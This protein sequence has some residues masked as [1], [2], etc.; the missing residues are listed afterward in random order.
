MRRSVVSDARRRSAHAARHTRREDDARTALDA[1]TTERG[2]RAM[3]VTVRQRWPD[4]N[5][6]LGGWSR[7]RGVVRVRD[8]D[9]LAVF[10][11]LD[12]LHRGA[13]RHGPE[14]PEQRSPFSSRRRR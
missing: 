4:V 12:V 14:L 7:T 5:R 13:V 9:L 10:G 8:F 3:I 6:S 2:Q 11:A 1:L